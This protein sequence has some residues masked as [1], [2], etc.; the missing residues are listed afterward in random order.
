MSSV[1]LLQPRG[2]FFMRD[3]EKDDPLVYQGT[4][5][6]PRLQTLVHPNVAGGVR[7]F[8]AL[9]P[10]AGRSGPVTLAAEVFRD[11]TKVGEASVPLPAPEPSGEIRYVG[12]L[13]TRSFPPGSYALRL[14]A[15]Q[16][17][18]EAS[19]EAPFALSADALLP[20]RVEPAR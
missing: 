10:A 4:A 14:L 19:S 8:V 16:A 13:V 15:R 11:G 9:Y 12:A 6:M 17:G 7:F 5:L 20:V 3:E 1:V 2:F 18:A